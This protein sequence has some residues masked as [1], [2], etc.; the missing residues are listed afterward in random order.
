MKYQKTPAMRIHKMN[1]LIVENNRFLVNVLSQTL[2]AEFNVTVAANGFEAMALL[3]RGLGVDFVLTDLNL[4]KFDGLELTQLIRKSTRYQRLPIL[5]LSDAEDSNTRIACLE[6]GADDCMVKPFN[7]FEV[8]AK[9]RAMLRRAA[10]RSNRFASEI[11][12][13]FPGIKAPCLN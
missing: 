2:S 1:I 12:A 10:T 6:N 13:M 8:Q 3:E 4:P 7:P 11:T 5:M 9:I